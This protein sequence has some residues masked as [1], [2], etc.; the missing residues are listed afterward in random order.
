MFLYAKYLQSFNFH[1]FKQFFSRKFQK[2]EKMHTF[3]ILQY[4][5][6]L[7][8]Y[9]ET[10]DTLKSRWKA[11]EFA[12]WPKFYTRALKMSQ[13]CLYMS[14]K[15]YRFFLQILKNWKNEFF[16]FCPITFVWDKIQKRAIPWN[17]GTSLRNWQ[18]SWISILEH[19]K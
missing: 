5:L 2:F 15:F 8:L 9:R 12:N 13:K 11:K 10:L 14:H 1:S 4:N 18:I 19:C 16:A 7:R 17:Y 3:Y 6:W